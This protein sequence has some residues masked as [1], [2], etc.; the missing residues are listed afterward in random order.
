MAFYMSDTNANIIIGKKN[1]FYDYFQG[2][3][4]SLQKNIINICCNLYGECCL[5]NISINNNLLKFLGNACFSNFIH[6]LYYSH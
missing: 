6:F 5:D 2:T 1:S 3:F 4:Y